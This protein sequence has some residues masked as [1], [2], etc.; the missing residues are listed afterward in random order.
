VALDGQGNLWIADSG[1]QRIRMLTPEATS[2]PTGVLSQV[3]I[4]NAA[5]VATGPIAPGEIISIFGSG[6]DPL[7]TQVLFAGKPAH[8]FFASAGQI[9]ALVPA[10]T[11]GASTDVS[12]VVDVAT[13]SDTQVQVVAAAPGLFLANATSDQAAA[14]NQDGS[15]NSSG[16]PAVRGSYVS[17]FATGWSDPSL[18]V[19]I[20]IGGYGATVLYAGPAPGFPGLMQINVQVPGGFLGPGKQ[21]VLLTVGGVSAQT[22]AT[23]A[24]Q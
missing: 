14:L 13:A 24:L 10:L 21:S 23:I 22:G 2:V 20:A 7:Q 6:F 11:P 8:V 17:L 4:V 18:V 9:N 15:H 16:N 1:N 5:S 19:T 3:S 12:I